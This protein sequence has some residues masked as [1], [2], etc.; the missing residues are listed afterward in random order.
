MASPAD[1][2]GEK[3]PGARSILRAP[4]LAP[5]ACLSVAT[6]TPETVLSAVTT[7]RFAWPSTYQAMPSTPDRSMALLKAE[8]WLAPN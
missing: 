1:S 7:T 6:S 8:I 5:A 3:V 2:N 4:A